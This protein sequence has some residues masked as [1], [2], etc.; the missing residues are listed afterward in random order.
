MQRATEK[1][2]PGVLKLTLFVNFYVPNFRKIWLYLWKQH[3]SVFSL[4]LP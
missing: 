4:N 3:E 1:C 2:L